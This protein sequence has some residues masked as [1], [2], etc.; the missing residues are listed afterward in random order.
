[1]LD[2]TWV[3]Y[4]Q[5]L[6]TLQNNHYVF[7]RFED[8]CTQLATHEPFPTRWVILRHDVDRNASN[9]LLMAQLET[10]MGIMGSY[11]FRAASDDN[12]RLVIQQIADLGHEIGYHYEDLALCKGHVAKALIHF[13]EQLSYL[14]QFYPVRTICMHGSPCSA[15]DNKSLWASHSYLTYGIIGEPYLSLNFEEV[16]YLTDTGR[17]WDGQKYSIR[18]KVNTSITSQYHTSQQVMCAA[19]E[20]SLPNNMMLTIHPQRWTD[21]RLLWFCEWLLQSTK[22]QLKRVLNTSQHKL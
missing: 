20:G 8:Y 19:T 17:C 11:Y 13:Q 4:K 10:H 12:Q 3:T 14:R 6:T 21:N 16:Y 22:N 15:F 18:D 2:F 7:Y 1:M 9:A 5:L